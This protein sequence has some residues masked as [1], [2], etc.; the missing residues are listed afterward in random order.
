M[1]IDWKYLS[2]TSGYRSL[3]QCLIYDITKNRR[4]KKEAYKLF[5]R[6]LGEAKKYVQAK[7][8]PELYS[9]A[10]ASVLKT[11]E[12]KRDYWWVNYYSSYNFKENVGRSLKPIGI[13]GIRNYYKKEIKTG[14]RS[15]NCV[16]SHI[17]RFL[18]T[19]RD[20]SGKKPRWNMAKKKDKKY[21]RDR[22]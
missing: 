18:T 16:N 17:S 12:E 10:L 11:W 2:S 13:K 8:S 19:E 21:W 3:K 7:Y 15:K 9:Y 20:K 4:T 1:K 22:A 5:Y 6:V 14:F